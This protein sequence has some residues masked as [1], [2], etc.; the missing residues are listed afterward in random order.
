MGNGSFWGGAI[1]CGRTESRIHLHDPA[2]EALVAFN[3]HKGHRADDLV[4]LGNAGK[5]ATG[6][7]EP[8][9]NEV[10]HRHFDR[11]DLQTLQMQLYPIASQTLTVD[12]VTPIS[13][14]DALELHPH[15]PLFMAQ[16]KSLCLSTPQ[17]A[18][19]LATRYRYRHGAIL[20]PTFRLLSS[21]DTMS[22]ATEP[23][24]T[25]L[26]QPLRNAALRH[27]IGIIAIIAVAFS[28]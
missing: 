9:S 23:K 8:K 19:P 11:E 5:L 20:P 26:Q 14:V 2:W 22:H 27:N 28:G 16:S 4:P 1:P 17:M 21:P 18:R 6:F 7:T 12:H 3:H 24:D 15:A 10:L 25:P 13:Q